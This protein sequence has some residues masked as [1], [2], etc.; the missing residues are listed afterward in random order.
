MA[1]SSSNRPDLDDS[2]NVHDAHA[3][4]GDDSV[5]VGREKS[6]RENGMEPVGLWMMLACGIVLLA[7]GAV[8]GKG[9]SLFAYDELTKNGYMRA[10]APG[11]EEVILPPGPAVQLYSREGVRHYSACAGCHGADGAGG[12]EYPPLAGSEWVSG[13]TEQLSQIIL[14][15]LA[16]PI[17]VSGK[18]YNGNMPPMGAGLGPKELAHLMSYIRTEFG[19][20]ASLVTPEMAAVALEIAKGRSG[21]V[22][23]EILKANHDK[24][25]PGTPLASDTL[26]DPETLEPVED[27]A[28]K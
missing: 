19:G 27:E 24:M 25:L 2:L 8:L 18:T 20:G 17:S 12:G 15:G 26:L 14:H 9:G 6:I 21:Q 1:T 7:G 5:A 4:L 28:A 16:G 13:N 22:N 10:P 23:V 3:T 11:G